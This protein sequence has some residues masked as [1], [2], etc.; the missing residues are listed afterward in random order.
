M[1]ERLPQSAM[2]L[3]EIDVLR[4]FVSIA[5]SGSFTRTAAQIFR[6]TSAVSMQ[7]KR[8]ENTLGCALFS[9]EARRVALTAEGERLISYARRLLKLNEEA[10]GAFIKPSLSGQVRFGAPAD[11]GTHI[12]PGLLS[13][14]ARTHPGIEVNVSVGRSVDMIQ[15]IDAG[16]LDVALISVG[17]LGQDDTR[18]EVVH[19]EPLVWAGRA[20]GVAMRRNPLPLALASAECAWRRQALDALDRVGRSYRIAY[21]SEQCAGQEAAMVADLAVAPYPLSLIRPPLRRLDEEANLPALGEYQI[22]L[23]SAA[24]C[25]EP[26]KVLSQQVVAAF[27]AYH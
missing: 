25:S 9:R 14:F 8:L 15:R 24:Q 3:L 16:E 20:G 6:T 1:P 18:G 19:R 17:N 23:L 22:K 10:V 13:L 26:V 27:A 11:I 4:T 12:L 21:S 5:E 7:I 2:P